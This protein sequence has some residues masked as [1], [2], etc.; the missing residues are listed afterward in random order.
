MYKI[1]GY[2]DD[3]GKKYYIVNTGRLTRVQYSGAPKG[4]GE[5]LRIDG[6]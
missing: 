4:V 2:V 6:I 3:G 5:S 1:I